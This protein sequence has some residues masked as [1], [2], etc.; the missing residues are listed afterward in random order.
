MFIE[1]NKQ[2]SYN[3]IDI[4]FHQYQM[5]QLCIQQIEMAAALEMMLSE[6]F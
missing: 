4:M 6:N 2:I 3:W 5:L 1:H